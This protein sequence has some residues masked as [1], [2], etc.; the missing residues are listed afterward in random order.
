[1]RTFI[2]LELPEK[3]KI[4]IE[5]IQQK[6]SRAGVQAR[7]VKPE[8][9]HLT[10]AFLGSITPDKIEPIGKILKEVV[11][12]ITPISLK[13]SKIGCFPSPKKARI[14]F[15][16]LEGELE[17]LNDLV[18]KIRKELKKS[19]IYFDDKPFSSHVT[20]G[21]IK[22]RQNLTQLIE[23]IKV[24]KIE[25]VVSRVSLTKSTLTESGPTYQKLKCVSLT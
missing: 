19:N 23:E 25:F 17:K 11:S 6:L 20:L 24:N 7:W 9:A 4:E 8:I 21:R 10:L 13:L 16:D 18:T 3:I 1:M 2:S 5:K 15:V 14:I 12:Q 22:D